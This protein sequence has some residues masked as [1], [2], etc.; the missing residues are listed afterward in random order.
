MNSSERDLQSKL[1]E[2]EAEINQKTA[3]DSQSN[4]KSVFPQVE[5]SSSPQLKSWI[6]STRARFNT[7]PKI[8]KAAVA[9]GAVWLGFSIVGAV[10]Q[11][12]SSIFT[13]ATIG[14]ILYLGY[15]LLNNNTDAN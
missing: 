4:N 9:I 6:D 8:G 1:N 11:V 3:S 14:F 13:V 10:L 12:V 15:R 7:L 5:I 2:M